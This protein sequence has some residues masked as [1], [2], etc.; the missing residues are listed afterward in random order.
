M[1]RHV[2]TVL[3]SSVVETSGVSTI[4]DA[5]FHHLEAFDAGMTLVLIPL[6]LEGPSIGHPQLQ[7]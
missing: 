2:F 4:L 6:S 3:W 7:L 1:T 5:V